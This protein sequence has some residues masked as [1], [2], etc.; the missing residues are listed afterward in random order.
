MK[1]Q[2]NKLLTIFTLTTLLAATM[3]LITP[4]TKAAI[5]EFD[6]FLFLMASPNPVGVTQQVLITFQ[7]DKTS[8][9]AFGLDQGDHFTG[10]TL[11]ITKPD[12]TTDML[13]PSEA[14]ATSGAFWTYTPSQVG[15]YTLQANFPGQWI[16][17]TFFG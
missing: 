7:L 3:L 11:T 2:K 9:T 13:G 1:L 5:L 14:W 12:G 6:T 10:F 4:L 15:T 8:P 17:T 16:N